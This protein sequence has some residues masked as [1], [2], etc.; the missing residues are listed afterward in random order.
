M[1]KLGRVCVSLVPYLLSLASLVCLAIVC[2]SCTRKAADIDQLY[3]FRVQF[4]NFTTLP[5]SETAD[6]HHLNSTALHYLSTA[7]HN[8]NN[9]GNLKDFYSVG[10]WGYC[11]GEVS[12]QG[13]YDT[14]YCSSPHPKFW[15]NPIQAW[16]LNETTKD[17][18]LPSHLTKELRVYKKVSLWMSSGY[19]LAITVTA[20]ETLLGLLSIWSRWGSC[21]TALVSAVACLFTIAGTLTATVTFS[22]L[23]GTFATV[24]R[25][26]NITTSL[27]IRV[28]VVSWA[29]VLF[30]LAA[31]V[32]WTV[33]MCCCSGHSS[34]RQPDQGPQYAYH[35]VPGPIDVTQ[36][37]PRFTTVRAGPYPMHPMQQTSYGPQSSGYSYQ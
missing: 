37:R 33:T 4:S 27:G 7:L 11:E 28:L 36:E 2:V 6:D 22:L 5:E 35:G 1:A 24:L 14:T 17:L 8:A 3:F 15:F 10:L 18:Q 23:K 26:L 16:H 19:I 9:D 32:F 13:S 29:A 20:I 34:T 31:L 30:S 25:D 12:K 21:I